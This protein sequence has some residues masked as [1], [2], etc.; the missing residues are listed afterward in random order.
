MNKTKDSND[1][2]DS[3]DSKDIIKIKINDDIEINGIVYFI[4]DKYIEN[5][6]LS[7]EYKKLY[8]LLLVIYLDLQ[9]KH[10]KIE[11]I[12][13]INKLHIASGIIIVDKLI[14]YIFTGKVYITN[15]TSLE[16]YM[17][18]KIPE[19]LIQLINP[20]ILEKIDL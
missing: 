1:S 10:N 2:K 6:F 14:C 12:T 15:L 18:D 13:S 19:S 16:K 9:L 20:N 3:K 11:N 5:K 17:I 8:K 4:P 7:Y